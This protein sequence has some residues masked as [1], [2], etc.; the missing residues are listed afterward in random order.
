MNRV[1]VARDKDGDLY[2]YDRKPFREYA[3]G[4][5]YETGRWITAKGN[6]YSYYAYKLNP[7]W[8]PELTWENS[9]I[10][11]VQKENER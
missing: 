5:S 8:F 3:G 4:G 7:D 10:E 11:L 1:W 9:P 2:V 6:S